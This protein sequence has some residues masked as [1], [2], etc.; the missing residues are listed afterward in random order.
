MAIK[1]SEKYNK[2]IK[3]MLQDVSTEDIAHITGY[4]IYYIRDIYKSLREEY[5]VSTKNG[6]A[7]AY[8]A[9]KIAKISKDLNELIEIISP[10]NPPQIRGCAKRR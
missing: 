3:L 1:K 5:D 8:L 2:I 10:A 9:E 7:V 6:I 4:S